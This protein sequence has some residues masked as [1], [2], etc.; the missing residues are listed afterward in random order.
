MT[1]DE[2]TESV[3]RLCFDLAYRA[4]HQYP[5]LVRT[6]GGPRDLAQ[7][8][9]LRLLEKATTY[10]PEFRVEG[11][12]VKPGT[13]LYQ[14]ALHAIQDVLRTERRR[15]AHECEL[16]EGQ[17]AGQP[18]T[19]RLDGQ[20]EVANLL[21][22]LHERERQVVILHCVEGWTYKEIAEKIGG[23]SKQRAAALFGRAVVRMGKRQ[24]ERQKAG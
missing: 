5:D 19:P 22:C 12:S 14:I 21:G 18:A 4:A 10:N 20:E 8:A 17:P 16:G 6:A 15:R 23:V 1:R 9:L 2:L 3:Y 24:R 7:A 13:Y 11:H